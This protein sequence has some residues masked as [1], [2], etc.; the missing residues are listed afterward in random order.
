M[1]TLARTLMGQPSMIMLDEPSEGLAPKV[2]AH[3]AEAIRTMMAE[4]L[5]VLLSEQNLRFA[6]AVVDRAYIVEK[7][8]IRF[9]GPM[10]A[11]D[12]DPAIAR[13]YLAV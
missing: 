9:E 12:R 1:L 6:R 10:A 8:R 5:S 3:L 13:T 4:G 11:L 7:G 2:V